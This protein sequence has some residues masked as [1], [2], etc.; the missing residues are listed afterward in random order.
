MKVALG[1]EYDGSHFHGWQ[2]Q[3]ELDT[4]QTRL[5]VAASVVA[6]HDVQV[7]CA[8][9]TDTGVHAIGQVVHFETKTDRNERSWVYG[10]NHNLPKMISVIWAKTMPDDF[11]ARFSA[12]SRRYQYFIYNSPIRPAIHRGSLT[13]HYKELNVEAMQNAAN[14]LI[15]EHDF[16]S[17]RAIDCQS[18]TPVRNII[19]C[20]IT[21]RGN[22]I[23]LDIKANAFLHHMVRN[24]V[25]VLFEVGTGKRRPDWVTDLINIRDRSKSGITAPAYGLYLTEVSYPS[26]FAVPAAREWNFLTSLI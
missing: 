13:W 23:V 3:P 4:I 18:N 22:L 17:F 15:G 7:Q 2:R 14:L 19:H 6:N 11:H 26:H 12:L 21:R 8:G 20:N 9:R 25:G 24:I 16:S 10:I 1:I 5:E